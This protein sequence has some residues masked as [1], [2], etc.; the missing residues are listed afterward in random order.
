[1]ID[2]D[3]KPFLIEINTNPDIT[4]S[5][6]VCK[7]VIPQMV[8]NALR[9]GVD[10]LFSPPL[11]WPSNKKYYGTDNIMENN[12]FEIIFDEKIDGPE[13]YKLYEG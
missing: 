10:P 7:K 13:L 4:T 5:S 2:E 6:P 12:K 11:I 1:M 9:I 8:D 3:F